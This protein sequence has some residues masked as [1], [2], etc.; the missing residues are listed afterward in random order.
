MNVVGAE[1]TNAGLVRN[2]ITLE[3]GK[4]M[5]QTAVDTTRRNLYN[6]G[7]FRRVEFDFGASGLEASGASEVP[8]TVTIQTEEPQRFQ[9]KYG[10]QFSFDQ[11]AGHSN[12]LALGG[13][14]EL[15]D[16]NFFGRAVQASVGA[17]W[18]PDL[19]TIA[20]LFSSPR[21]FGKRIRTNL[22]ARDRREQSTLESTVTT[23][24][25]DDRR[26]ELTL[27]QRWRTPRAV[28]L[29]WGYTFS[30][31]HFLLSLNDQSLNIDQSVDIGQ[32]LN[33]GGL[34]GG[35]VFSVVVDRRD[36]PFDARRGLFHS[37]SFQFGVER[38]GS[39]LGLRPLPVAA[40]VPISRWENSRP[41]AASVTARSQALRARRRSA[42]SIC[43][44]SPAAPILSVDIRRSSLS[45]FNVAGFALGGTELL[46]LN[47]E[48]R[49]PISKRLGGAA[50][51]DAG[52]TFAASSD[53][54]LRRPGCRRR[55]RPAHPHAPCPVPP[56][57]R[58]AAQPGVRTFRRA[59]PFFDRSDVLT[60]LPLHG[61]I[62][63]RIRRTARH[64]NR[65]AICITVR[66]HT[67]ETHTEGR[68]AVSAAA[69]YP[70][71]SSVKRGVA[72]VLFYSALAV[73]F[74]W[75]LAAALSTR[76][77][78]HFD[79]P[80]SAWRLARVVH[81]VSQ[82]RPLFD[83]EIFWPARQTLAYSDAMLGQAVLA[84]PLL[85]AGL[86][87]LAVLNVLTLAGVAGSAMGAYVLA[88][89]LSGHTGGALVAGLIFAFAPYRRD[90]LQHLELQ[91]AMWTPLALWAWHRALD[92]GRARDGLLCAAFVL[93]QL[94]SSIYYGV[95]LGVAMAV[96]CPLT[97]IWRRRS[98]G[99]GAVGGLT[100]GL[101]VVALVAAA[102]SRP[103]SQARELVGERD[104]EETA[105]Y[106]ADASSYLAA[107]PDNLLYGTLT[108]SLGDN[109]KRL[110]PGITAIALA[111]VALFPPSTPVAVIYGASMA[112]AWDASLGT[113]G[114]I[115]PLLRASLPPFRSLRAPARFA[116]LVLL[117]M[118]VLTAI[119]LA[120]VARTSAGRG[121]VLA[122]AGL[123]V[124][125]YSTAPLSIQT[126]PRERP[127][128]YNWVSAQPR[129]VTLELP[130]PR[131][132]ALPL[133]D[134][135]YMYAQT[136]HW[137]PL[138]NGYSGYHTQDYIDLLK[139]LVGFPD[140]R[141]S[142]AMARMRIQR[143]ILH[144]ELFRRGEYE[145]L[146]R[147]LDGH[148]DYHPLTLTKDHL[149][150]ARVYAFLPG[151]GPTRAANY[152]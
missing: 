120:R 97:L 73:A 19:Q 52:N 105:R 77:V 18:D 145:Q 41:L 90:H 86:T 117:G 36:S 71:S 113:S 133:H 152:D 89:R 100:A 34:L 60:S 20:L 147:A 65:R 25:L 10:L 131:P 69:G 110:F 54:S 11:S 118:S 29:V 107:T 150:E 16:R 138:A 98:L 62:N 132:T 8:L 31:R 88:R 48:L 24:D 56:R 94:L 79:P 66:P 148:P 22:Y 7:S 21:V 30:S 108:E 80:F 45:A 143:V 46:I 64:L 142:R 63:A 57:L 70:R 109:E 91:W 134:T 137:H 26:R 119:G 130:V 115:Y 114:R 75:P 101:F 112:V 78:A 136:W 55:A 92:S 103:Y 104:L 51:V 135:F 59:H 35:P 40:V 33:L 23:V 146:V 39:D 126:I 125:E 3:P 151:F 15:R 141:S 72:V 43:C 87:P 102:Y 42:S 4:V 6:I 121:V 61:I 9:L 124:L 127:P 95:F 37:S 93:L 32:P 82:G 128:V 106:S 123:V 68:D 139:A 2:A 47:G 14:V 74:T 53:L 149:G 83:G 96:I 28:E 1:T 81:N 129:Q 144:R 111:A 140:A 5:G 13:S 38:L 76:L 50:F 44:S 49:F 99:P 116:M 84:W 17:H 12:G 58:M 67:S 122:A 27:E 85:A